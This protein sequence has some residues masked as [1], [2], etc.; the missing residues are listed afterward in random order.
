MICS[1]DELGLGD[2]HSGIIVLPDDI[3]TGI[4]A[5]EYFKIETS[6]IRRGAVT[7]VHR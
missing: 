4:A 3:Q 2:D 1:E 6:S 5:S 7:R